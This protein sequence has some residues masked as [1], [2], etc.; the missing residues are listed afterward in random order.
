MA[1]DA[2]LPA[3]GDS[4]EG[5]VGGDTLDLLAE[6][7]TSYLE[8]IDGY[9]AAC[10]RH[11]TTT[12]VIAT[13]STLR[14]VRF[15]SWEQRIADLARR[16]ATCLPGWKSIPLWGTDGEGWE[17]LHR[18]TKRQMHSGE[19]GQP[20]FSRGF[21]WE[22]RPVLACASR[23]D[24]QYH[25]RLELLL[26]PIQGGFPELPLRR[27]AFGL[28]CHEHLLPGESAI[29]LTPS[30]G[31]VTHIVSPLGY[32]KRAMPRN[33]YASQCILPGDAEQWATPVSPDSGPPP[34]PPAP[35]DPR[36]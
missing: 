16:A 14:L 15:F 27:L 3:A 28:A 35:H 7:I 36:S 9:R 20:I 12:E 17:R 8:D 19:E 11:E 4:P 13:S 6:A 26:P 34:L 23:C 18:I 32:L 1:T 22:G 33:L 5:N 31:P 10:L 25:L 30:T 21:G 29:T 2:G 24:Q